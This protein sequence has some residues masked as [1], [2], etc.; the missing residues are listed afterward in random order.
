MKLLIKFILI[1]FIQFYE[2]NWTATE[3]T[4]WTVR[5]FYSAQTSFL[6]WSLLIQRVTGWW[7]CVTRSHTSISIKNERETH[8]SL[9]MYMYEETYVITVFFLRLYWGRIQFSLGWQTLLNGSIHVFFK[10]NVSLCL[11]WGNSWIPWEQQG[12]ATDRFRIIPFTKNL[13]LQAPNK[14]TH[15]TEKH[16]GNCKLRH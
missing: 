7:L 13:H 3:Y 6:Q 2:S 1:K 16:N 15:H 12:T 14:H 11:P 10:T 9:I 8:H 4:W 5:F